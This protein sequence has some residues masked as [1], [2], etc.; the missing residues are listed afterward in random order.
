MKPIRAV[1]AEDEPLARQTLTDY[2]ESV[3]WIEVVGAAAD[4]RSAVELIDDLRPDLVFLDIRMPVMSGLDVVRRVKHHPAVVFTTAFDEYAVTAF[5]LEALDYLLKPFGHKRLGQ[6]LERI[7]GRL[8]TVPS[9]DLPDRLQSAMASG[10]A[11]RILVRDGEAMVPVTVNDIVRISAADDYSM[12][13]VAGRNHLVGVGLGNLARRL[14][15]ARFLRVHRSH[16][17]NIEHIV[18]VAPHD[19][20]RLLVRLSDGSEILSSR[21]GAQLLRGLAL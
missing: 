6:A 18:R 20:R 2:L 3:E 9:E 17:V 15:P 11:T 1:L 14:D 4:G 7:R 12:L 16:L 10:P 19:D 13:H 21:S 8:P 5:E